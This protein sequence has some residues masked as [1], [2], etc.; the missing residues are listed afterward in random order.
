MP[1]PEKQ[2][3]QKWIVPI[4]GRC[5]LD[6]RWSGRGSPFGFG[7]SQFAARH[8]RRSLEGEAVGKRQARIVDDVVGRGPQSGLNGEAH[9]IGDGDGVGHG[10]GPFGLR[11]QPPSLNIV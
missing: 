7:R 9:L 8:G 4:F 11:G 5:P 2:S 6:H 3:C 1:D 10:R